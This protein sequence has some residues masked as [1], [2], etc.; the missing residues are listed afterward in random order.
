MSPY[1]SE[2]WL[3][4][5]YFTMDIPTTRWP[6]GLCSSWWPLGKVKLGGSRVMCIVDLRG[7]TGKVQNIYI[8]SRIKNIDFNIYHSIVYHY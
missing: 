5:L 1:D 2:V 6:A 3:V 4:H 8:K 7:S